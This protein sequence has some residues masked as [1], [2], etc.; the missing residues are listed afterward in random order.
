MESCIHQHKW[1]QMLNHFYWAVRT[2]PWQI[3]NQVTKISRPSV[4]LKSLPTAELNWLS[5]HSGNQTTTLDWNKQIYI[6]I[7]LY[8]YIYIKCT[9]I[10][11]TRSCTYCIFHISSMTCQ[12]EFKQRSPPSPPRPAGVNTAGTR[13]TSSAGHNILSFILCS[14]LI[15]CNGTQIRLL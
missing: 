5:K 15:S 13:S 10:N 8:V 14:G 1:S 11:K 7:I 12:F 3:N 2:D 6:Y 4:Q 9:P